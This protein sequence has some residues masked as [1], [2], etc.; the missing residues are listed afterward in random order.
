MRGHGGG[1]CEAADVTDAG[2]ASLAAGC[3][4]ITTLDLSCCNQITDTGL[5]SLAAGCSAITTLNL[6][7]C[8]QITD[9]GL[10]SLAAG[11]HAITTL[12]LYDLRSDHGHRAGESGCWMHCYHHLYLA[13]C[14]QITDTGLASLAAGCTAITTLNRT[15]CKQITDTGLASR[16][17]GCPSIEIKE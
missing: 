8:N 12:N 10:A 5:A 14:S 15:R 9:T 6:S 7:R 17:A 4:A 16:A 13:D 1:G 2:L 11:C 3:S